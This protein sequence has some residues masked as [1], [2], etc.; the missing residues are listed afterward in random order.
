MSLNETHQTHLKASETSHH[1]EAHFW[2]WPYQEPS[3]KFYLFSDIVD[4]VNGGKHA[5]KKV[6]HKDEDATE[7]LRMS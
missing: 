2:P 5:S 7:E 1:V 3:L 4:G 6:A